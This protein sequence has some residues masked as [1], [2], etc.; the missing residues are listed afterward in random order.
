MSNYIY[1][2][3]EL[4]HYGVPGMKWGVRHEQDVADAKKR[5]KAAKQNYKVNGRHGDESVAKSAYSNMIKAKAEYNSLKVKNP[6]NSEKAYM[7]TYRKEMQK[8]G[9]TD[10][11]IDIT[12]GGKSKLLYKD[13][14]KNKGK[15]YAEKVHKQVVKYNDISLA[16]A[17][18]SAVVAIGANVALNILAADR[19]SAGM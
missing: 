5:Y 7:K 16:V 1:Y 11:A 3:G 18:A 6:K 19:L 2:N 14:V 12:S 17:T 4:Y 10:S 15:D 8:Y 9:E 13:L